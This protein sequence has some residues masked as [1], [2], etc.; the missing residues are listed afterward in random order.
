MMAPVPVSVP[1]VPLTAGDVNHIIYTTFSNNNRPLY[2]QHGQHYASGSLQH[3]QYL[4]GLGYNTT[5]TPMHKDIHHSYIHPVIN[6]S[7]PKDIP[8]LHL[9][10]EPPM[11]HH[12]YQPLHSNDVPMCPH[13]QMYGPPLSINTSS[14]QWNYMKMPSVS[15]CGSVCLSSNEDPDTISGSSNTSFDS[16]LWDEGT[17]W[18]ILWTWLTLLENKILKKSKGKALIEIDW[19]TWCIIHW[20]G[21]E[22]SR[23]LPGYSGTATK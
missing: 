3:G 10:K 1:S 2:H 16:P 15:P 21:I 23:K 22:M 18:A 19:K 8:G 13:R 17:K 11:Y 4:Q 9:H 6:P 20:H 5:C 7:L 14:P 12:N